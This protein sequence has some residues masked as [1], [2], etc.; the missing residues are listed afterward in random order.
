ML[1]VKW[2]FRTIDSFCVMNKFS[3]TLFFIEDILLFLSLNFLSLVN[4]SKDC[5][6]ILCRLFAASSRILASELDTLKVDGWKY[7]SPVSEI[8]ILWI[9]EG[10]YV[11]SERKQPLLITNLL[12][13]LFVELTN[14]KIHSVQKFLSLKALLVFESGELNDLWTDSTYEIFLERC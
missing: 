5:P 3:I 7:W 10:K 4:L 9:E 12:C 2:F 8:K 6:W 14:Y 13:N 11:P 1:Q